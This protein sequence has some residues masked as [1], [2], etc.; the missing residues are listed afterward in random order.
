MKLHHPLQT[1][2]SM[3]IGHGLFPAFTFQSILDSGGINDQLSLGCLHL[4]FIFIDSN[5]LQI[6]SERCTRLLGN[7][8][9][10]LGVQLII[11]L[12]F[13][14]T[15]MRMRRFLRNRRRQCSVFGLTYSSL[16]SKVQDTRLFVVCQ[17]VEHHHA[18]V[19]SLNVFGVTNREQPSICLVSHSTT[20]VPDQLPR[21]PNPNVLCRLS[22]ASDVNLCQHR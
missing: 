16:M 18:L 7:Y 15:R 13:F 14:I 8:F 9:M 3:Q 22:S 6:R 1:S 20:F 10:T 19:L 11:V 2:S 17:L 5:K 12:I 21:S 4:H